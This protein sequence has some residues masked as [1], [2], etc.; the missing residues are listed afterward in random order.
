MDLTRIAERLQ[1]RFGLGSNPNLRLALYRRLE[2][3]IR[4]R[5]K[6]LTTSSPSVPQ[7]PSGKRTRA[8]ISRT[9]SSAAFGS[10]TS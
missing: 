5:A 3:V 2:R 6:A 9:A 10:G 1:V 8:G 7:M 4:S